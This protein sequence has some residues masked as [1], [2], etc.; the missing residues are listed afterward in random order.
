MFVFIITAHLGS[1]PLHF[2]CHHCE[3]FWILRVVWS[4]VASLFRLSS[5]AS[6]SLASA[7]A[8]VVLRV[9]VV[10]LASLPP[11]IFMVLFI[12][13]ILFDFIFK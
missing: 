11:R 3:S 2:R 4:R 6:A 10:S 7:S 9:C 5:V 1:S 12:F 13:N 8:R